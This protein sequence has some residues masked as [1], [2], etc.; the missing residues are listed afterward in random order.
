MIKEFNRQTLED[1][2]AWQKDYY[3][4]LKKE[5]EN[6]T[7][8][9]NQQANTAN[10][11]K[12]N[13]LI[14]T[15]EEKT[16]GIN[17]IIDKNISDFVDNFEKKLQ[18]AKNYAPLDIENLLKKLGVDMF[19]YASSALKNLSTQNFA[20]YVDGDLYVARLK[21]RIL[22]KKYAA[23]QVS[24][25]IFYQQNGIN[26]SSVH[27][28]YNIQ[29]PWYPKIDDFI[30]TFEQYSRGFQSI[31]FSKAPQGANNILISGYDPFSGG[32]SNLS[33]VMALHL[34]GKTI[35]ASNG[36]KGFIQATIFPVRYEDFDND[37]VENHF[38][39]YINGAVKA[40]ATI[41][42]N[43]WG[44]I[45][46]DRLS[47]NW[48]GGYPDNN[49]VSVSPTKILANGQNFYHTKLPVQ[50]IMNGQIALG[51]MQKI[52]YD[53]SYDAQNGSFGDYKQNYKT[54]IPKNDDK[55][56]Y[57]FDNNFL[58]N[59]G[60]PLEGSGG[61]FL[62]NEI[63][64][65]VSHLLSQKTLPYGHF[66]VDDAPAVSDRISLIS[67]MEYVLNRISSIL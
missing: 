38:I 45:S 13:N 1:A 53:Q 15:H 34:H 39:K 19:D 26:L 65:R 40:M 54:P 67:E 48:R 23:I 59:K 9:P 18:N 5:V 6:K 37:I 49:Q 52:Y 56:L 7:S 44:G 2:N 63:Y 24:N 10:V 27:G 31:D 47:A 61:D 16:Y 21:I 62:S 20:H 14:E 35:T 3:P 8:N 29:N 60:N 33:G 42:L 12:A 64:Y 51:N 43:N 66:H 55:D 36:K 50:T 11:L 28:T 4:N 22:L 41:S 58:S 25:I 32:T 17:A 30:A 57:I 46:I